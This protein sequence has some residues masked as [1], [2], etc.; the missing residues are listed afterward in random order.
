MFKFRKKK[1]AAHAET[2][3]K[4]D[5]AKS[6]AARLDRLDEIDGRFRPHSLNHKLKRKLLPNPYHLP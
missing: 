5:F 6:M 2:L 4:D 1:T 3:P